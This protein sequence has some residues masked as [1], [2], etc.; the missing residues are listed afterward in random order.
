MFV[1]DYTQLFEVLATISQNLDSLMKF[2]EIC[3][4]DHYSIPPILLYH[5]GREVEKL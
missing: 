3:I 4:F 1:K 2:D 5:K